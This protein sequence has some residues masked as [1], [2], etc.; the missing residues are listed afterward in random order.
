MPPSAPL[1]SLLKA[2][3]HDHACSSWN[4][5]KK[6][7]YSSTKRACG[8]AA[9]SRLRIATI[10]NHAESS[11]TTA[12]AALGASSR[13]S[14]DSTSHIGRSLEQ[15]SSCRS[16]LAAHSKCAADERR[17]STDMCCD[18]TV[19]P[20]EPEQEDHS[21]LDSETNGDNTEPSRGA[22]ISRPAEPQRFPQL[23][24]HAPPLLFATSRL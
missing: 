23:L 9:P 1:P 18:V 2:C 17:S 3:E 15:D 21:V 6:R 19:A 14:S 10:R 16:L 7:Q 11:S 22:F 8:D 4:T 13:T 20:V 5:E 24:C 12:A